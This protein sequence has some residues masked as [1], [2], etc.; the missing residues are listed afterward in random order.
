MNEIENPFTYTTVSGDINSSVSALSSQA[1]VVTTYTINITFQH[2]INKDSSL[3]IVFPSDT[4]NI[5]IGDNL[6]RTCAS[7]LSPVCNLVLLSNNLI[8]LTH[9]I[10]SNDNNVYQNIVITL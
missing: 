3:Q 6:I 1:G 7:N 10:S 8:K 4:F 9:I 5:N 2:N